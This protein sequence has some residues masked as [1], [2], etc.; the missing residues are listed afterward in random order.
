[1]SVSKWTKLE[2]RDINSIYFLEKLI[3]FGGFGGVYRASEV[4]K[5]TWMRSIAV[6]LIEVDA[7]VTATQLKELQAAVNFDHPHLIRCFTVGVWSTDIGEFLYLVMELAEISLK[8]HLEQQKNL[9]EPEVQEIAQHI[10]SALVEVHKQGVHRDLKPDNILRIN[11]RWKL[12][13]FGIMREMGD[14]SI[15][16]T[17]SQKMSL[18][19]APPEAYDGEVSTGWDIW[20][21]G[22]I[23]AQAFSGQ[24]PYEFKTDRELLKRICNYELKLPQLPALLDRLVQGCLQEETKQRLTATQLLDLLKGGN[25]GD[26]VLDLGNGVKLELVPISGGTFNMG[27]N[28]YVDEQPI[29]QVSLK[30]F[31]MGKYPVTQAQYAAIM[32]KN[33]SHFQGG[34]RP[35]EQVSWHDAKEFCDRLSQ[36]TGKTI[37]LPSEA[38]WEYVCRAGS[39]GAYCFGD[40]RKQLKNY[41]WF[42]DNS[43]DLAIDSLQIWQTDQNN[44]WARILANNCRTHPVGEKTPNAW[45]LYDLHGNVWEWC[46]DEWHEDY[47]S[48]PDSLKRNGNEAWGDINENDNRYHL[49]R[50]GSWN[51]DAF[52]CRSAYRVM[53]LAFNRD[54]DVGFRVVVV[55]F[56]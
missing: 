37:R 48:K 38:E 34:D 29:H 23:I 28:D 39:T 1:M 2:G 51:D 9:S 35:V 42:G 4:V 46:L 21:L 18:G 50:G 47:S 32:G 8:K 52:N 6:K 3:G 26:L 54:Y 31:Y 5:N 10:A 24:L 14:R 15:S 19:Y 56:P 53:N 44:Y 25:D 40:D 22:I 41:A 27:S 45:G 55:S 43:G 33:P 13:D 20:S 17:Q 49:L 7:S 36:R 11:G 16:I 30:P 12:S